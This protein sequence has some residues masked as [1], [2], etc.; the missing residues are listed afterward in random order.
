MYA[1]CTITKNLHLTE[2]TISLLARDSRS[3]QWLRFVDPSAILVARRASEIMPLLREVEQQTQERGRWAAGFISYEA[4]PAFDKALIVRPGSGF[5][6]AW[7]ALYSAPQAVSLPEADFPSAESMDWAPSLAPAEYGSAVARIK[8]YIQAG[9]TYQVNFTYRLKTSFHR[10]PWPFFTRLLRAQDSACGFFL[11]IPEWCICS[12]SPELF[13]ERRGPQ[14]RCRPM[15]GTMPRGRWAEEDDALAERLRHSE[16]NRAENLMIVDM[17]RNDMGRIARI[18]SVQVE[19]LFDIERYPTL[20]Q[21]TSTIRCSTHAGLPELLGALFPA[22]SI[23]GAPKARTMEIIAELET[24]P[25]QIYTGTAGFVGPNQNA[26]FNVAIRT[27]LIDKRNAMAEYGVGGGIVWDSTAPSE[28]MECQTKARL[29]THAPPDF[30][31]LE[32]LLWASREGWFLLEGH[33][34]RLQK[35]AAYFGFKWNKAGI[36]NLLAGSVQGLPPVPH[37]VR[38]T[39][40]REAPPQIEVHPHK[41][42]G[43]LYSLGLAHQPVDSSNPLLYHKTTHRT[44]YTNLLQASPGFDDLLLWNERGEVTESCIANIMVEMEGRWF[45]PPIQCGLLPGVYRAHLLASGQI[46]ERVIHLD[47]LKQC[48]SL[49]LIN[50]LRKKWQVSIPILT[51]RTPHRD[52]PPWRP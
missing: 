37:R 26:H 33:L 2:D 36:L 44:V 46:E 22:A 31:L 10:A 39:V 27:V 28:L 40:P 18:G 34:E 15:K 20:W 13:F 43:G 7:F 3:G 14:L 42:K 9:D 30:S 32:T 11:N 49:M 23:T 29:L 38:L 35:S 12:A 52:T 4:A 47:E 21:M 19:S 25:R 6:L 5:P 1:V 24:E 8:Q 16:K 41:L 48:T 51:S 17:M 50:S 45:T